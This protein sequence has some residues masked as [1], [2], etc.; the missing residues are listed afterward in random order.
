MFA[1]IY[2][3]QGD[4]L[5]S[6][7]SLA[8]S[9]AASLQAAQREAG[10]ASAAALLSLGKLCAALALRDAAIGESSG[11]ALASETAAAAV[12]EV[13]E[14]STQVFGNTATGLAIIRAQDIAIQCG[15]MTC[16]LYY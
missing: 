12:E 8:T 13:W 3:R 9:S 11:N 5:G 4:G 2:M 10:A 1:S 7:A 14:T 6:P 15:A 16:V